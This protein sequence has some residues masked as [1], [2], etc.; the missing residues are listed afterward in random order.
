MF[1]AN[2]KQLRGNRRIGQWQAGGS[3]YGRLSSD[4]NQQ[5][6][7]QEGPVAV[8]GIIDSCAEQEAHAVVPD[9]A[10]FILRTFD[11]LP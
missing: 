1:A 11:R 4:F 3:I 10:L 2:E 9:E 8:D 7:Q 5:R 6:N